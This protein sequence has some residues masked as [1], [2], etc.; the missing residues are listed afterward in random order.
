MK[1]PVCLSDSVYLTTDLRQ[2]FK[3]AKYRCL[4]CK[5]AWFP[6]TTENMRRIYRAYRRELKKHP[7]MERVPGRDGKLIWFPKGIEK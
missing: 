3:R 5:A 1:C 7:G 4:K 6:E 2:P